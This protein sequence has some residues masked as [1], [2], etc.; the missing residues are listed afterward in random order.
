MKNK[1]FLVVLLTSISVISL[2]L[3]WTRIFSAEFFYT[4]A[5]LILS[6]SIAGL[7]MGAL[8]L[9]LSAKI[10]KLSL[11]LLLTLSA[12][13]SLLGPPLV[14]LIGLDFTKFF[15][16]GTEIFKVLITVLILS[17]GFFF[18]GIV[19]AKIFR[20][21][22]DE[23]PR[24]YM[25]DLIGAGA[26]CV[27]A[28]IA[29][30]ILQTPSAAAFA[31]LPLAISA[32]IIGANK[33]K[34]FPGVVILAMILFSFFAKDVLE[35]KSDEQAPVIYRHWDSMSKIKI[36]SYD[37]NYRGLNTDNTAGSTVIGFDGNFNRSDTSKYDYGINISW[38]IHRT[39]PCTFLSLGAGGGMDVM[40]ALFGGAKD[41]YAVE[42]NPHI[43]YLMTKGNLSAFTGNIYSNSKVKVVTED[44][45]A[46]IRRYDKKIDI[47]FARNANSYAALASGAFA[48]AENYLFTTEAFSDYWNALSDKGYLLMDHQNYVPRMVSSVM[49]MLKEKGIQNPEQ[50]LAVYESIEFRRKIILLSKQVLTAEVRLNAFDELRNANSKRLKMI[51][52]LPLGTHSNIIS[53]IIEQG[54]ENVADDVLIDLSPSID[55]RP[56]IAQLGLWRNLKKAKFETVLPSDEFYGFPVS[57]I[58]ILVII[59]VAGVILLPLNLLPYRKKKKGERLEFGMWLYF[60]FIGI[61]YMSVE[62]VL[63]QKYTLF[64]GPSVYGIITILSVLLIASGIGSRFSSKFDNKITFA[65]IFGLLLI[66]VFI[67]KNLIYTFGGLE[68]YARIL[69]TALMVFPLGF[70]MGMPFPKGGAKVGGMIDWAFAVNGSASVLGSGL[71]MLIAFNYGFTVSLILSGLFYLLSFTLLNRKVVVVKKKAK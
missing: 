18:S 66:D 1:N 19:L 29:M 41:I 46:Y 49:N 45:R 37:E 35:K 60:F 25:Y 64:I 43:N 55:N 11:P 32:I 14:F 69:I 61:A 26:G 50:H 3:I 9:R 62:V 56:F 67:Y 63:I 2:E 6:L 30:N 23:L 53:R 39:S 28:L 44:A 48:L 59:L 40:Q 54:W 17:G 5:F 34:L 71:V 21:G 8:A 58:L 22:T 12:L 52:P 7:G 38:L 15:G 65:C 33:Q 57:Q 42:V 31:G 51:Y 13:I 27:I 4:F 68:Q 20:E 70:F 10:E 16:S 47:I 36:L 24:L